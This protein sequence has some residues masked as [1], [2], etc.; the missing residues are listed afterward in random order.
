MTEDNSSTHGGSR[1]TPPNA[2]PENHEPTRQGGSRISL[3]K[4]LLRAIFPARADLHSHR[5]SLLLLL[6]SALFGALIFNQN[7]L[8]ILGW[9][10]VVPLFI[11][12]H[13]LRGK[14]L[15]WGILGFGFIWYYLGM[16]WLHTLVV[17]H[18]LIP[19]G[20]AAGSLYMGAYFVLFAIPAAWCCRQVKPVFLPWA[21]ATCWTGVE[22]LRNFTDMAL[23]WNLL[24]HSQ[25]PW[26]QL[27]MHLAAIG[28]VSLLSFLM[29]L[30]NGAIAVLLVRWSAERRLPGRFAPILFPPVI[31]IVLA[32]LLAAT[33]LAAGAVKHRPTLHVSI[34][35]PGISQLQKW[36]A[37]MGVSTDTPEQAQQRWIDTETLMLGTVGDLARDAA[38][39]DK[40]Q[41]IVMPESI[42]MR[43]GFPFATDLQQ[44]LVALS[45]QTNADLFFGADNLLDPA[46]YAAAVK[47]GQRFLLPG[48]EPTPWPLAKFPLLTSDTGTTA[49]DFDAVNRMV[50][51]VAA[52]HI[53]RD[54][55][56]DTRVYNKMQLVP[57][58]EQIP[59][60]QGLD[61]LQKQFEL[62]GIAGAYRP[63]LENTIFEVAGPASA[64]SPAHVYHFGTVI[65]FE[66]TF[67]Y[68][69]R[70]LTR[71]GADFIC[72]LTNDSW[73]DPNYAISEGGFWGTLFRIPGIHQLAAAGPKQHLAQS[74][75]RALETGRAIVR[76][77]N[78]GISA[79]INPNGTITKAL[80]YGQSG[81][82]SHWLS[83]QKNNTFFVRYGEW[84]GRICLG[85]WASIV[86]LLLL[87]RPKNS[88]SRFA[89]HK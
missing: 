87:A 42:F 18:W 36:R 19:V 48:E 8:G 80:P 13:D 50:A 7:Y 72:V 27:Y 77:A 89:L 79:F 14:L 30:F 81:T 37:M 12:L 28:G 57:F 55:G 52:W 65:C 20:V 83:L 43:S 66:S 67:S 11:A 58:G 21:L 6:I 62:A 39:N 71:A 9:I 1:V 75:F 56:L 10:A 5:R 25:A 53:K 45:R 60:I 24:G 32:A 35:Q 78:T 49:P 44:Q 41:L 47:E 88:G 4:R 59:F 68:L 26:N 38:H 3:L 17:F 63:G 84:L 76:S 31:A 46:L 61:W 34:I 82:L 74:Q 16:F 85:I 22:Y 51:T 29:A 33:I 86:C 73:Y 2:N 15:I 54:G 23:P 70:E 40:P 69:T 64:S